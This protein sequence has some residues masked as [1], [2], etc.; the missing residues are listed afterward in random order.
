MR[1]GG[2]GAGHGHGGKGGDRHV[3]KAGCTAVHRMPRFLSRYC[4]RCSFQGLEEPET[5]LTQDGG[6]PRVR[7]VLQLTGHRV[8]S[9]HQ[10]G[11]RG[12]RGRCLSTAQAPLPAWKLITSSPPT[13]L[14]GPVSSPHPAHDFLA[15]CNRKLLS[16]SSAESSTKILE[17]KS[18]SK[19]DCLSKDA[20]QRAAV[21]LP[22]LRFAVALT[23]FGPCLRPQTGRPRTGRC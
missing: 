3:A 2:P 9:V 21:T 10:E 11:S 12:M 15:L 18:C 5:N 22:P 4:L 7:E 6:S 13:S 20:D 16:V 1:E 17:D 19:T 14:T 8:P 23:C